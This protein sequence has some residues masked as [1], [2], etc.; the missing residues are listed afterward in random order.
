MGGHLNEGLHE[1]ST[2]TV[3]TQTQYA[4]PQK[5]AIYEEIRDIRRHSGV[6]HV[7]RLHGGIP[8]LDCGVYLHMAGQQVNSTGNKQ[9]QMQDSPQ[10]PGKYIRNIRH[11][12]RRQAGGP[13]IDCGVYLHVRGM[14]AQSMGATHAQDA[15]QQSNQHEETRDIRR[16]GSSGNDKGQGD[17]PEL[18]CGDCVQCSENVAYL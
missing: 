16:P 13:D 18:D 2:L 10:E 3:H 6:K 14:Q 11:D 1:N 17:I 12:D 4:P 5:A 15:P 7:D 8:E 9:T